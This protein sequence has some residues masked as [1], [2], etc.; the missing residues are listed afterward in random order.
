MKVRQGLHKCRSRFVDKQPKSEFLERV[1]SC[2]SKGSEHRRLASSKC[3]I[4]W[5]R[6]FVGYSFPCNG[7]CVEVLNASIEFYVFHFKIF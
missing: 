6:V 1:V 2:V 4:A 7:H 5:L 3:T